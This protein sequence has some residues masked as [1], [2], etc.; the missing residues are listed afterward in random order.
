M[1]DSKPNHTLCQPKKSKFLP[2]QTK[3]LEDDFNTPKF[4]SAVFELIRKENKR[5]N[6]LSEKEIT[7]IYQLFIFIDKVF[8]IFPKKKKAP[9][10]V[11]ELTKQRE[12]YRQEKNWSEADNIRKKIEKLGY[13]IKDTKKGP[14][15]KKAH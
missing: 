3:I 10:E 7:E 9:Q 5:I 8:K 12:K 2:K 14:K 1:F 6:K 4:F 13:K 15:I 11:I